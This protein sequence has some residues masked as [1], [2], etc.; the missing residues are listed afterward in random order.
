MPGKYKKNLIKIVFNYYDILV[1]PLAGPI[2]LLGMCLFYIFDKR[3]FIRR[4][5]VKDNVVIKYI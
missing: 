3:N 2:G 1:I 5:S 4:N